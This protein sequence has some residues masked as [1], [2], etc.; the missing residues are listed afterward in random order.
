MKKFFNVCASIFF[1]L[2]IIFSSSQA[3]AKENLIEGVG[4][5][6]MDSRLDETPASATAR[7]REEAKRNA[8]EKAGVYLQSYSK[9]INLELDY[10]EV[11]TVA[12]RLLKIQNETSK[13]EVVQENLLKFTVTI[14]AL[15]EDVDNSEVLKNLMADKNSLE[16]A[17]RRNNEL[18]KEYDDLKKQMEELKQNFNSASETQKVELKKV[19]AQNNNFFNAVQELEQGNNFYQ[20]KNFSAALESYNR[21]LQLNPQLAEAY[22]NRGIIFHELNQETSAIQDYS[23]A[24][25]IKP[26]FAQALNNR[27]NSFAA[28]GQFQNALNDLKAA[29]KLSDKT[30][31]IHNNLGS[32]YFSMKNYSEAVN[33]YTQAINLNSNYAEAYYNR[34]AVFYSQGK[35]IDALPDAK[36][37]L[38][39]NST[40]ADTKNLYEKI[41]NKLKR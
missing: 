36:R 5:Y 1:G 38:D 6:I 28:L 32:V 21:A 19:A 41:S 12:A 37:A 13:V 3:E 22:N 20:Q 4:T 8:T 17:V 40:D 39:L 35:Y 26:N 34:A 30:A 10:D 18:Q 15:V 33:E 29:V 7:A 16:E 9:M 27:G 25:K 31:E 23:A 24:I 11:K 14:N 2:L